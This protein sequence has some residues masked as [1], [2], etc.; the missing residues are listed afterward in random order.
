MPAF[1]TLAGTSQHIRDFEAATLAR[2]AI[3]LNQ[4][5]YGGTVA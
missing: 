4:H 5:C 2:R 3:V 1:P